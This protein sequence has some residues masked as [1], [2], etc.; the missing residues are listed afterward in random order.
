[1][2][3]AAARLQMVTKFLNVDQFDRESR[4]GVRACASLLV[5]RQA[6]INVV[7]LPDIE[8]SIRASKKVDEVHGSTDDDAIVRDTLSIRWEVFE[9]SVLDYLCKVERP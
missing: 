8:R 5:A 1:L 3:F 9:K 4:R 6:T 2:V 7:R